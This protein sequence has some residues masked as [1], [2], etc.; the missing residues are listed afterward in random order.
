MSQPA[1]EPVEAPDDERVAGAQVVQARVELWAVADR[2][3][4]DVAEDR[5]VLAAGG[6]ERVELQRE[7]LLAGVTRL[8][9]TGE[10]AAD[11]AP[12]EPLLSVELPYEKL[13]PSEVGA[14]TP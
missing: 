3:G 9:A 5:P 14:L 11:N 2:S 13:Q 4:A 7:V 12:W 10:T 1:A 6:R 8:A